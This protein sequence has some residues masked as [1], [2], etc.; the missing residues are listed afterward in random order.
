M[1]EGVGWLLEDKVRHQEEERLPLLHAKLD[2][3]L[4]V[5]AAEGWIRNQDIKAGNL[6]L[7]E[8]SHPRQ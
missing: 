5:V 1:R 4:H 8:H 3:L 6:A 2:N 7:P